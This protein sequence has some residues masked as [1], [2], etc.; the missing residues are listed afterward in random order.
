MNTFFF[1]FSFISGDLLFLGLPD[2]HFQRIKSFPEVAQSYLHQTNT[3]MIFFMN[4]IP[5]LVN[6]T[7]GIGY[8]SI[9]DDC[10]N[11]KTLKA[12]FLNTR[13]ISQRIHKSIPI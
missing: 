12:Y 3:D 2:F 11:P 1:S 8:I 13:L 7:I 5:L 6:M 4:N 9:A 10:L